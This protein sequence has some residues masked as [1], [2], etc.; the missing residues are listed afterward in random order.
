[1]LVKVFLKSANQP[2]H[3]RALECFFEGLSTGSSI[4]QELSE[5]TVYSECDVAVFFG[6]WKNRPKREHHR[7]KLSIVE[8]HKKD[9]IMLETPLLGCQVG[10]P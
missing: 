4:Q 3:K 8:N 2:N 10:A 7:L 1:M 9:F 6:S 5:E